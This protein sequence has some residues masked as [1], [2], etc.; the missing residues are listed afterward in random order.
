MEHPAQATTVVE[1]ALG[2][3]LRNEWIARFAAFTSAGGD[4]LRLLEAVRL[5]CDSPSAETRR[6]A[7]RLLPDLPGEGAQARELL[8]G[9]LTDSVWTVREAAAQSAGSIADPDGTF[10]R[11]LLSITLNDPSPHVRH[12]AAA[13]IGPRIQPEQDYGT[14]LRHEFERQRIR[15]IRA[16]VFA[17][18]SHI[19]EVLA[20]LRVALAD[21]HT[22]VRRAALQSM[23]VLPR[24]A[25]RTL[26]PIIARKC[27]ETNAAVAKAACE[28]WDAVL[29][30]K[31]S[32]DPL[33][34]LWSI[35]KGASGTEL[36]LTLEALPTTYL[37]RQLWDAL[38]ERPA[39]DA[40]PR[41]VARFVARLCEGALAEEGSC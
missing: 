10:F 6:R 28:V 17:P 35:G 31:H 24:A 1:Q 41:Q 38:P 11:S 27:V 39:E 21:S 26:L 25:A 19:D 34:P 30:A 8:T 7:V 32:D 12:A 9:A 16:I 23:S 14:G 2:D 3:S 18:E 33:C 15:A 5:L 37:L 40:D 4:P 22:K 29:T 13:A 20:A 36:A